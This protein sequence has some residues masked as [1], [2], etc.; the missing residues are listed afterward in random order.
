MVRA[1]VAR[2][3]LRQPKRGR[4]F[5]YPV[6]MVYPETRNEEAYETILDGIRAEAAKFA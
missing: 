4:K 3:R 2:G 6:Y 5:V 1:L